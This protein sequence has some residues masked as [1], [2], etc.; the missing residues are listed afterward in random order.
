MQMTRRHPLRARIFTAVATIAAI[1][2][3]AGA[4]TSAS[5]PPR[6]D[7]AEM[8][9]SPPSSNSV[10]LVGL[11]GPGVLN[12]A[13]PAAFRGL[14]PKILEDDEPARYFVVAYTPTLQSNETQGS[15][16]VTSLDRPVSKGDAQ[17]EAGIYPP[18]DYQQTPVPEAD[19]GKFGE[20]SFVTI[21]HD[22]GMSQ[23]ALTSDL[24][25]IKVTYPERSVSDAELWTLADEI[26]RQASSQH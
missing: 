5:Q 13:L 17:A 26:Q 1:T 19:R 4:C 3:A 7:G 12:Q 20:H 11:S 9:P 10:N 8:S 6:N 25:F 18:P 14:H 23:W 21:S 15:I 22:A 16:Q 2:I 24:L